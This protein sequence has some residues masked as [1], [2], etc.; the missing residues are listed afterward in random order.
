[1]TLPEA[2][3]RIAELEKLTATLSEKLADVSLKLTNVL[4]GFSD[5]TKAKLA[6]A[7]KQL[8]EAVAMIRKMIPH[9]SYDPAIKRT[10]RVWLRQFG[11]G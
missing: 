8:A 10:A 11:K 2:L 9:T 7:E 4:G 1:M 5:A 6:K 3:E